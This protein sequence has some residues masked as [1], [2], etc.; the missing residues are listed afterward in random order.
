MLLSAWKMNEYIPAFLVKHLSQRISLQD[1][2]VVVLGYTFKQDTDDTRDSLAP[3]LVR[4]LERSLPAEIRVSDHHLA[5]PI[6]DAGNGIIKNW[7]LAEALRGAECV[8]VATNHTGYRAALRTL[9]PHVWIADL[10]NVGGADQVFYP[11]GALTE[12]ASKPIMTA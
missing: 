2:V 7:P 3:K 5:D 4:Y 1:R 11:A 8:F 9:P 12:G 6:P 10:W